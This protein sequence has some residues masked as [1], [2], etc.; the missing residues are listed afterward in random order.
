M[1]PQACKTLL[2]SI[3]TTAYSKL[4]ECL[5]TFRIDDLLKS[6]V[7]QIFK[8]RNFDNLNISESR[9]ERHYDGFKPICGLRLRWK[10]IYFLIAMAPCVHYDTLW[11]NN[12]APYGQGLSHFRGPLSNNSS[13]N[14][15]FWGCCDPRKCE[16][17]RM[18]AKSPFWKVRSWLG[19]L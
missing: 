2:L 11:Q 7:S 10:L 5:I 1:N 18:E 19:M 6:E 3:P 15:L 16:E 12:V 9:W 14:L 8:D 17:L 4:R 13:I